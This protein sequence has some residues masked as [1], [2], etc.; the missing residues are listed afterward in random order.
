MA[1]ERDPDRDQPLPK[2]GKVDIQRI[3]MG[4]IDERRTFGITKYGR[5]LESHNG[6]D[7]LKDAWEEALDLLTYLTQLRVERGDDLSD[8]ASRV[9]PTV[10][11]CGRCGHPLHAINPGGICN[12]P[13][14]VPGVL[15]GGGVFHCPCASSAEPSRYCR[16]CGHPR[17][18]DRPSACGHQHSLDR[19]GEF[20]NCISDLPIIP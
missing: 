17:H 16:R 6:R 2:P 10:T 19:P 8:L 1:L 9:D 7:A 4:A 15:G 11:P 12:T 18:G 14:T 20:C 13:Y 3:L 5:A